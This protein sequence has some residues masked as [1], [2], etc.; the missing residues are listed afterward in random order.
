MSNFNQESTQSQSQ[1]QVEL[2]KSSVIRF[3][4][5]NKNVQNRSEEENRKI[6]D[7]IYTEKCPDAESE[8]KEDL[9]EKLHS[10]LKEEE[11]FQFGI[12]DLEMAQ[13]PM[14]QEEI[15]LTSTNDISASMSDACKDGRTKMQ[16][17]HL[18]LENIIR[19]L[20]SNAEKIKV[21]L[22][23]AGFDDNI[24]QVLEQ[25]KIT[26]DPATT[27]EIINAMKNKLYPRGSTNIHLALQDASTRISDNS[28]IPAQQSHIFMTDGIITSGT[29]DI[30]TLKKAVPQN[31][32]NY[33]IGFGSDHDFR[34]LQQLAESNS[35]SDSDFNSGSGSG[36]YYYVDKI[37]NAGLV[38][39]EIIHN[40]LYT[41]IRNVT[42]KVTNG[43]IYDFKRNEWLT[44]I[45]VPNLCG[46]AKKTFH[47]RSKTP[48]DLEL[49]LSGLDNQGNTISHTE[50]AYPPLEDAVTGA[51]EPDCNLTKFMY[52]QKVLELLHQSTIIARNIYATSEEKTA[53]QEKMKILRKEIEDYSTTQEEAE[54]SNKDYLKQL[55]DDLY[56][57]EKTLQS[58]KALLYSVVRQ[59]AQ[60]RGT[61]YNMTQI[62]ESNLRR[63]HAYNRQDVEDDCYKVNANPLSRAYT[64]S[65]QAQVMRSCSANTEAETEYAEDAETD[66]TILEMMRLQQEEDIRLARENTHSLKRSVCC[67]FTEDDVETETE[68]EADGFIKIKRS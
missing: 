23:I 50:I 68:I 7:E 37:E 2:I 9:Q 24:L 12:F 46:E 48:Y 8:N 62:D 52:R 17:L 66:P 47:I 19:L 34:L 30:E 27:Q 11:E 31:C 49:T 64:S 57:S 59:N 29:S 67:T 54:S 25:T 13:T 5:T 21:K 45:S 16:H 4:Y 32:Q 6:E 42:I 38:F 33:F 35:N 44:E 28:E 51:V 3:H 40:I 55:T 22:E 53:H 61:S 15:D 18:T 63:Q 14:T 43:E 10:P 1:A 26:S 36:S 58:D 41:S 39:G 60:G 56:I 20:S 65:T